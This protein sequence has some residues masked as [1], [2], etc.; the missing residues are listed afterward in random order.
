MSELPSDEEV[1]RWYECERKIPLTE[2]QAEERVAAGTPRV[3]YVCSHCGHWHMGHP[4]KNPADNH[5]V[6]HGRLQN[7]RKAWRKAHAH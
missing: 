6:R 1:M 7:A 4:R 2:A 5:A 3:P